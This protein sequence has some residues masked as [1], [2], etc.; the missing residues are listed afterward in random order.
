MYQEQKMMQQILWQAGMVCSYVLGTKSDATD[1]LANYSI[2]LMG[3]VN[4]ST[5]V[6][7]SA[8]LQGLIKGQIDY[9]SRL[10]N[11]L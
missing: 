2:S 9:L 1:F 11:F 7:L 6:N 10:N 8:S 5:L 3:V 4:R